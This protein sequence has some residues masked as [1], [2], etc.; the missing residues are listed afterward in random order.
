MNFKTKFVL[1]TFFAFLITYSAKTKAQVSGLIKCVEVLAA[2]FGDVKLTVNPPTINLPFVFDSTR[3]YY[4]NSINGPFTYFGAAGSQ[5]INA[6]S[7]TV[8][9]PIPNAA[10]QKYYF[11]LNVV[12]HDNANTNKLFL[13]SDTV[14]S[15]YLN[16]IFA[17]EGVAGVEWNRIR[18]PSY[19]GST[20][21]FLLS[22]NITN[23]TTTAVSFQTTDTNRLDTLFSFC[24]DTVYYRVLI[25][26]DTTSSASTG[27][28]ASISNYMAKTFTTPGPVP[29]EINFLT[30]DPI[31]QKPYLNWNPSESNFASGYKVFKLSCTGPVEVAELNGRFS[32]NYNGIFEN[33]TACDECEQYR[34]SSFLNCPNVVGEI[35]QGLP[36][37]YHNTVKLSNS[38]DICD[39]SVSLDWCPYQNYTT[40]IDSYRVYVS[41]NYGD[42]ELLDIVKGNVTD[43]NYKVK[44]EIADYVYFIMSVDKSGL[45]K[46][47]SYYDTLIAQVPKQPDTLFLKY[48]TVL[49]NG[50]V[51]GRFVHDPEASIKHY[52]LLRI[53]EGEPEYI[54]IDEL[55]FNGTKRILQF[56]DSTVNTEE[57]TYYYKIQAVDSCGEK[58]KISNLGK[59]MVFKANS[60]L[61]FSSEM[62]WTP[63]EGWTYGIKHFKVFRSFTNKFE[64]QLVAVINKDTL[65]Y[66]DDFSDTLNE[67]GVYC[68]RIEAVS[69]YDTINNCTD[70]SMSN[71]ICLK[72]IPHVFIPNAFTPP[73]GKNPVFKPILKFVSDTDY[74]LWVYDRYGK[75]M[76][77]SQEVELGWNGK[78]LESVDCEPGIYTYRLSY[79]NVENVIKNKSG[80]VVLIR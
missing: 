54:K 61:N 77:H 37:D 11:Y 40:G 65:E 42:Y 67:N 45:Y 5:L 15:M 7:F 36:S 13:Y 56:T 3:I 27:T 1:Y 30:L 21:E 14:S 68:Y 71:F 64:E 33:V 17:E 12:Y 59:T 76:F 46:S 26:D 8:P 28:C 69:V 57:K 60:E 20:N 16:V 4:S 48:V 75:E 6:A 29:P 79:K 51:Q 78:N 10:F 39:Y 53:E 47:I 38:F 73:E 2:P 52:E 9:L 72:H 18:T 63:Y 31:T 50:N 58:T 41:K 70:S 43:Y 23:L 34:V 32:V 24:D 22:R 55:P 35:K 49:P 62:S 66:I 25:Q 74:N 44:K 80:M 19:I